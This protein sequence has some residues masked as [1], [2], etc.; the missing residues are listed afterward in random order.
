MEKIH[1]G[2]V[3][4]MEFNANPNFKF[5][6]TILS[7]LK[8]VRQHLCTTQTAK[9]DTGKGRGKAWPS[10]SH[11]S[12]HGALTSHGV[13]KALMQRKNA[14]LDDMGQVRV[15]HTAHKHRP[16]VRSLIGFPAAQVMRHSAKGEG[17]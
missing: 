10:G 11:S 16:A 7:H 17:N 8:G 3:L 9:G 2:Q 15:P 14:F 12:R 1:G 5:P 4:I 6:P 13:Q